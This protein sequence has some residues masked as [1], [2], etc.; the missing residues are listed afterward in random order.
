MCAGH[1]PTLRPMFL[2]VKFQ[3]G[4]RQTNEGWRQKSFIGT[5]VYF[6]GNSV[7][8]PGRTV[9][10]VSYET[11]ILYLNIT[12]AKVSCKSKANNTASC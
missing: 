12:F 2:F 8:K 9:L 3:A 7:T 4:R 11:G 1:C 6:C 5:S 10:L